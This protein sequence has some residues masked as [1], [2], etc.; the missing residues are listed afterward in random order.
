VDQ[1]L[2]KF[3]IFRDAIDDKLN[4]RFLVSQQVNKARRLNVGIGSGHEFFC[5]TMRNKGLGSPA[6]QVI[7]LLSG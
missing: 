6:I 1:P 5:E 7:S 4:R 3:S 2:G